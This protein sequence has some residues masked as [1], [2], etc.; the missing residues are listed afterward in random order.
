MTED[1]GDNHQSSSKKMSGRNLLQLLS[2]AMDSFVLSGELL[3]DPE[4]VALIE[5][6]DL[7]GIRQFSK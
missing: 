6:H 1:A 2:V 3:F 5:N 4:L 7:E